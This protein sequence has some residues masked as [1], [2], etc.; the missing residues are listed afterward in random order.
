ML[1]EWGVEHTVFNIKQ[2]SGAATRVRAL[3]GFES[4]PTL[5]LAEDDSIEP[6]NPPQP[7][8]RGGSPRGVDRGSVISE[9]SKEQLRNWLVKNGMLA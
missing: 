6:C 5:V 9:P 1:R 7:L 8:S 3:T 4:V 2:D